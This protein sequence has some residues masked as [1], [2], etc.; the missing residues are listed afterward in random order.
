M[1]FFIIGDI[2]VTTSHTQTCSPFVVLINLISTNIESN[3]L[4]LPYREEDLLTSSNMQKYEYIIRINNNFSTRKRAREILVLCI[5]E[6]Y[7]I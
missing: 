3:Q 7:L 4:A 5:I 2:I 6:Y 1:S